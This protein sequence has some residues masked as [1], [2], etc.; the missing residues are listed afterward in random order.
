[1]PYWPLP[2]L[3]MDQV[4]VSFVSMSL[5]VSWPA[6]VSVPS[7]FTAPVATPPMVGLSLAPVMVIVMSLVAVPPLPSLIVTVMV[8]VTVWPAARDCTL[9]LPLSSTYVHLPV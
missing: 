7:S 1:M 3:A 6:V 5:L 8:S 2:L 9:V 4:W